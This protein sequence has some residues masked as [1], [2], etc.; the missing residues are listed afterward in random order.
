M[1]CI[2]SIKSTKNTDTGVIIRTTDVEAESKVKT[3]Y[4]S[5]VPK[6]E[7]KESRGKVTT[8]TE[9]KQENKKSSKKVTK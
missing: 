7:W 6:S 1:K 9:E 8:V 3:G 5:Y 4:W 2:K